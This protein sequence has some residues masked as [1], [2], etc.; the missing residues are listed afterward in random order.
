MAT[1]PL[2]RGAMGVPAPTGAAPTGNPDM[3]T[4]GG[5]DTSESQV[6]ASNDATIA[7]GLAKY[8]RDAYEASRDTRKMRGIDDDMLAA[9]RAARGE[10]SPEK[11]Q[12]IQ[13]AQSSDVYIRIAANKIRGVAAGL[14]DVYTSTDR[15]WGIE[16]TA[17]PEMPYDAEIESAIVQIMQTEVKQAQLDAQASGQPLQLTPQMLFNRRRDLRDILYQHTMQDASKALDQRED[18]LDDVLQQGG[19]YQAL[20][21]FLQD[22]A[23]F[24]CAVIKGPVVYYRPNMHWENGKAVVKN[25]PT[26]TWERCSPFDVYFAPWSQNAQDG[27]IVHKQRTTRAALQALIGLPSYNTDAI[28]DILS[29]QPENFKDWFSYTEWERSVLEQRQS[30]QTQNFRTDSV[31]RPFPMLEYHGSVSGELLIEWGM[32][33]D[34]VPDV[35]QD[36]NITAWLIDD[37]VI[38]V[39]VNPHPMGRKPFYVDSFERVPGSVYGLGVPKMIEDLQDIGNATLRSMVNNMAISSGPQVALNEGRLDPEE[40]DL[41]MFPWKVWQFTDDATGSGSQ[42]PI[43]FF[44]PNSNASELMQILGE[45]LQMADTF[46]SMPQFMQGDPQGM[47]TIG[48]TSSGLS[49]L[50]DAANRTMKQAVTSIDKNVIEPAISDLNIYLSLTRPDEVDDGDINIIAKGATQL[51]QRDQLRMRRA[52][53]LQA[54]MNPVDLQIVGPQFRT[55]LITEMA[56]DLQIPTDSIGKGNT[57]FAPPQQPGQPGQQQQPNN[58]PPQGAMHPSGP[59][60]G[61]NAHPA[62]QAGPGVSQPQQPAAPAQSAPTNA[63]QSAP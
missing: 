29:R 13:K 37:T 23:T 31:D 10:Y 54:T 26:M 16:P 56:K 14:R 32:S 50:M 57:N 8:I 51:A 22:I 53:F 15:P 60:P 36:L 61:A 3:P 7:T 19:F 58:A 6:G 25:E 55:E 41:T 40:K 33:K 48:R 44:Q 4:A 18:Q 21:E 42:V 59:V 38:G 5:A 27:Y 12:E 34:Q 11:L 17:E 45:V 30:D 9:L 1:L 35:T 62:V 24:P 47:S 52:Q 63:A 46:S 43:Q 28:K 2:L 39:R 20:W 49:M